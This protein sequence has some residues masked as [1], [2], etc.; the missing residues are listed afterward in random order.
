MSRCPVLSR[1]SGVQRTT[2]AMLSAPHVQCDTYRR[3]AGSM[4]WGT[5]GG[6]EE[7]AGGTRRPLRLPPKQLQEA[8]L[9][10]RGPRFCR[11]RPA[12]SAPQVQCSAHHM[13]NAIHT[14]ATPPQPHM[15][16]KM[17]STCAMIDASFFSLLHKQPLRGEP[18]QANCAM[19]PAQQHSPEL[20]RTQNCTHC[21]PL[22]AQRKPRPGP[23]EER[24]RQQNC[25]S[26]QKAGRFEARQRTQT[27]ER[28]DTTG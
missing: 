27:H 19:L 12:R 20:E 14:F 2:S 5:I 3:A 13:C 18:L 4:S 16:K 11:A 15:T 26:R 1:A 25:L 17:R 7:L 21:S 22:P 8:R 9:V 23:E 10:R 28:V 6:R 24:E